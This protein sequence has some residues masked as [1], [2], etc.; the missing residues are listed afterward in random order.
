MCVRFGFVLTLLAGL[1]EVLS[2]SGVCVI[3]G[4]ISG[5]YFAHS[6]RNVCNQFE[7]TPIHLFERSDRLGGRI[8]SVEI[9]GKRIE[10]GA[11]LVI[12]ENRYFVEAMH[13]FNFTENFIS[14][15]MGDDSTLG[16]FDG[17]SLVF[18]TSPH[19]V[20]SIARV[21]WRYG[22]SFSHIDKVLNK[23]VRK[24]ASYYQLQDN[25]NAFGSA[26]AFWTASDLFN[27]TQVQF[28]E[29]LQSEL[30]ARALPFGLEDTRLVR[31]VQEMATG[32]TKVNYNQNTSQMNGLAGMIAM[33]GTLFQALNAKEGNDKVVEK[34]LN[35]SVNTLIHLNSKVTEISSTGNDGWIVKLTTG[36]S[37]ECQQVVLATPLELSGDL[38]II[39]GQQDIAQGL[40]FRRFKTV[41]ATFV[42]GKLDAEFFG[43]SAADT[44]PRMIFTT[45]SP[46]IPF[47]ALGVRATLDDG[48]SIVKFFSDEK[49]ND[50][51]LS[52]VFLPGFKFHFDHRWDA[53]PE[54]APPERFPPMVI[55]P[56]LFYINSVENGAS[57]IEVMAVA[58]R[59]V[60]LLSC[61]ESNKSESSL[62]TSDH[63]TGKDEL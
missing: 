54:F 33:A 42:Q 43:A 37:H 31:F 24:F 48:T 38:K 60:A 26:E 6:F 46:S 10:V 39:I 20:V 32:V 35:E 36:E 16:I 15:E 47:N 21:L 62:Q 7:T 3:G 27:F 23:V 18:Q 52:R 2:A 34:L 28:D 41:W 12:T 58:A 63:S 13:R 51:V 55:A 57:C 22:L 19:K 53:Y 17:D 56:N 44:L 49:L 4:G 9:A 61:R 45:A 40:R 5:A 8:L 29:F 25:S 59:N 14:A 11:S 1:S 50:T 30:N